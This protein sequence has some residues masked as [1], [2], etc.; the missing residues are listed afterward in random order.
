MQACGNPGSVGLPRPQSDRVS[1]TLG[2]NFQ[3]AQVPC[4][5]RVVCMHKSK[6]YNGWESQAGKLPGQWP[7]TLVHLLLQ[8]GYHI[9]RSSECNDR[10]AREITVRA[11]HHLLLLFSLF[12]PPPPLYSSKNCKLDT[13]GTKRSGPLPSNPGL[14]RPVVSQSTPSS[15][16]LRKCTSSCYSVC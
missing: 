6:V 5:V 2:N 1:T 11:P 12:L 8:S 4:H 10:L 13:E 3:R 7:D 15:L 16:A 9:P 14:T